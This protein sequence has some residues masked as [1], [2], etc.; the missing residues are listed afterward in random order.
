MR[1]RGRLHP[2]LLPGA[3]TPGVGVWNNKARPCEGPY[4][5]QHELQQFF[6]TFDDLMYPDERA[7]ARKDDQNLERKHPKRGRI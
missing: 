7:K 1:K 3:E 2:S 6:H 4:R 5:P